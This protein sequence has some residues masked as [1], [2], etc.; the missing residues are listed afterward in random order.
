MPLYLPPMPPISALLTPLESR[1]LD[2]ASAR[3]DEG[4]A[5]SVF[6]RV[7]E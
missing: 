2:Y 1:K 5:E 3:L 4:Q 6:E 7:G